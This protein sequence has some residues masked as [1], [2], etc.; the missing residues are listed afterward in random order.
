M[1][2]LC[3]I[4]FV[5]FQLIII[6]NASAQDG[7]DRM[8]EPLYTRRYG[9]TSFTLGNRAYICCGY[10]TDSLLYNRHSK[11]LQSFN[12]ATNSWTT[13]SC[14]DFPGY[15]RSRAVAFVIGD[16]AYVGTGGENTNAYND[17]YRFDRVSKTWNSNPIIGP[18]SVY[19]AVA[20]SIG[21]YG[22][23][24]TGYNTGSIGLDTF[25][26]Y[27][28]NVGQFFLMDYN[29]PGGNRYNAL[30][31]TIGNYAYFGGGINNEIVLKDFWKFDPSTYPYWFQKDTLPSRKQLAATFTIGSRGY[32]TTGGSLSEDYT[33]DI[34]EYNSETETWRYSYNL[35]DNDLK[36]QSANGFSFNNK[37]YISYGSGD[38][39]FIFCDLWEFIPRPILSYPINEDILIYPNYVIF[40]WSSSGDNVS[41]HLQIDV[42]PYFTSTPLIRNIDNIETNYY[43]INDLEPQQYYWR[44][45]C[46]YGDSYYTEW[47][48][49]FYFS[50]VLN[51]KLSEIEEPSKNL[52]NI[53][54]SPNPAKD[55]I[56]IGI[57]NDIQINTIRI[58]NAIGEIIF[59]KSLSL[60]E[61]NT[62]KEFL[63]NTSNFQNGVYT[64]RIETNNEVK[65]MKFIISR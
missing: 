44:V 9:A 63:I 53:T 64:V 27:D 2:N 5:I 6:G 24:G 45:R 15:A 46:E 4:Q 43:T 13:D 59:Q 37:G 3:I 38:D 65:T 32:V 17:W 21:N 7:W 30:V 52:E 16:T 8:E 20:F 58:S 19:S 11:A 29:F 41:Y 25:F 26:Y 10:V 40:E 18:I 12:P 54:L 60:C 1:K 31:F 61:N 34:W 39:N 23:F 35:P 47:S 49:T 55:N 57:N 51:K 48:S 56:I 36:R 62:D 22:Y 50:I 14:P 28:P 33:N 42:N